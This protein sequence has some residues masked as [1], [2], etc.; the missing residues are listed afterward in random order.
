MTVVIDVG[1]ARHG[2]SY[3]VERLLTMFKPD[4]LLGFDPDPEVSKAMPTGQTFK[5]REGG[6]TIID[7][8]REAAWTFDGEIGFVFGGTVAHVDPDDPQA[9]KV[10]CVDLARVITSLPEPVI[11]K[12]DCEGAEYELLEHLIQTGAINA[13]ERVVV[14][15][16]KRS[17]GKRRRA[18]EEGLRAA[19]VRTEQWRW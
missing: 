14:E 9:A 11:L 18:I 1:C 10:R 15:W 19:G 12:L 5:P 7:L 6:M 16:H 4:M 17:D 13:V 2:S 3:S 8:R